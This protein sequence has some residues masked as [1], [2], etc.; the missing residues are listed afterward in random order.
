MRGIRSANT[1]QVKMNEF[2][3]QQDD[4]APSL[5]SA[6]GGGINGSRMRRRGF[7]LFYFLFG[8]K[9]SVYNLAD[10]FSDVCISQKD[11]VCF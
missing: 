1:I 5:D 6:G 8:I 4:S 11:S 2:L 7:V 10:T 9:M 3:A